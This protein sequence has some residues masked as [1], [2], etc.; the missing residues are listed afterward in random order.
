MAQNFVRIECE[1]CGNK[2]N[3]YSRPSTEVDCLVCG[4]VIATPTGGVAEISGEI[5]KELEVE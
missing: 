3:I 4:E 2:Q 1:E 5:I